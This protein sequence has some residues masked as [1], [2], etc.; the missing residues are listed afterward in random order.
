MHKA[1]NAKCFSLGGIIVLWFTIYIDI[2][3]YNI[4][5]RPQSEW[6]FTQQNNHSAIFRYD[7]YQKLKLNIHII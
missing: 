5:K 4:Y 6:P 3:K 7:I 1:L 2:L